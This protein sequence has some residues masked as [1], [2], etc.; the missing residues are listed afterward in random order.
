MRDD[1]EELD[2]VELDM[3]GKSYGEEEK[4]A[5]KT[6][7]KVDKKK[8]KEENFQKEKEIQDEG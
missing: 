4:I 6:E 2:A 1:D 7:E 5:V 8:V 3:F